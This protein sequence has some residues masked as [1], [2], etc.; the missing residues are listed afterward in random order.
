M[1]DMKEGGLREMRGKGGQDVGKVRENSGKGKSE[2]REG[3]EEIGRNSRR[4]VR[5]K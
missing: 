2:L 3:V 1:K 5:G 4:E